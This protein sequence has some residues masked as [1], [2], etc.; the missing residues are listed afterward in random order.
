[1]GAR[2][3]TGCWL[4]TRKVH[5]PRVK[6]HFNIRLCP[7]GGAR[8]Q[9]E[10]AQGSDRSHAGSSFSRKNKSHLWTF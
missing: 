2:I 4:P 7:G 3:T 5:Y 9:R 10:A 8:R 6:E 1:M